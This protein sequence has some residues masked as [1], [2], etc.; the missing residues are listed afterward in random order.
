MN[1]IDN[2]RQRKGWVALTPTMRERVGQVLAAASTPEVGVIAAD[3][4]ALRE[5]LGYSP[6]QWRKIAQAMREAR[7]LDVQ[8]HWTTDPVTGRKRETGPASWIYCH[9]DQP[10]KSQLKRKRRNQ[11]QLKLR[12]LECRLGLLEDEKQR[13]VKAREEL[14]AEVIRL[15]SALLRER[16]RHEDAI[17]ALSEHTPEN[18][19]NRTGL[20]GGPNRGLA[21]IDE[22]FGSNSMVLGS[23]SLPTGLA[24]S[25]GDEPSQGE[26]PVGGIRT[27]CSSRDLLSGTSNKNPRSLGERNLYT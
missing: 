9:D 3:N 19:H 13:E 7:L 2:A 16:Q 12:L 10:R 17:A 23:Q 14:Q 18:R 26:E 15:Q 25:Q 5:Q 20:T 8:R 6:D 21:E 27:W 11:D 4:Q 22:S 1:L 24:I